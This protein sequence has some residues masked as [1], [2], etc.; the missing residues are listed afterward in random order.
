MLAWVIA[1]FA[2][3]PALASPYFWR[4]SFL[5]RR[6]HL[7]S[8]VHKGKLGLGGRT[9]TREAIVS[10][11]MR[12]MGTGIFVVALFATLAVLLIPGQAPAKVATYGGPISQPP[13]SSDFAPAAVQFKVHVKKTR[14]GPR[15]TI[16]PFKTRNVWYACSDG[17]SGYPGARSELTSEVDYEGGDI[18]IRKNNRFSASFIDKEE[19]EGIGVAVSGR[20]PKTGPASGTVRIFAHWNATF[21]LNGD[22]KGGPKDCDSGV[23]NWTASR[24][25]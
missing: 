13:A 15:T 24:G 10:H 22:P 16:F 8:N 23:L 1:C 12:R 11:Q 3:V 2:S 4:F 18:R 14:R 20:V 17:T 5:R 7:D 21:D 6:L 25:G 9:M 19:G